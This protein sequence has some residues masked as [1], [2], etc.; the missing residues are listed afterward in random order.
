MDFSAINQIAGTDQK[1][2]TEILAGIALTLG[3][4]AAFTTYRLVKRASR[5]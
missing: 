2:D 1:R 4:A 3:V 5:L